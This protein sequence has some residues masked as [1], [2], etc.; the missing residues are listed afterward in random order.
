MKKLI[1]I[2][3]TAIIFLLLT[4]LTQIGGLIYLFYKPIGIK[5]KRNFNGIRSFSLRLAI[6]SILYL[7]AFSLTPLLSRQFDRV[8]MPITEQDQIKPGSILTCL[9]NRHYVDP[10]LKQLLIQTANGLPDDITLIYL[11]ANF[12]FINGFPLLPHLSH[13]DGKKID[14]AFFYK[15][16]QGKYLN[17][18]KSLL[19]YGVVEEPMKS[20]FNQISSC[21]EQGYW[22]YSLLAKFTS[23]ENYSDYKFDLPMT[24]TLL[25]RLAD[26]NKTGKIFI[27]PHLKTRLKLT[28][29]KFR[30]HGCQAVRHDDHIHLQL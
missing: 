4:A 18:T 23:Q 16:D 7:I 20:E 25:I 28:N 29:N 2:I 14:L 17:K 1:E 27:E 11:D 21:A 19:G 6:F 3:K 12:P 10:N 30:F 8:P 5:I 26:N 13:N 15:N 9:A 24:K 22:Q